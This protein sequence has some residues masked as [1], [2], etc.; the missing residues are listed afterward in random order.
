MTQ[1]LPPRFEAA[2]TVADVF[3]IG[4]GPAG[5]TAATLLA[6]HG[7]SVVL[8]DKDQHP[9]FHIGES[10]LPASMRL[11]QRLGVAERLAEIGV[12]KYAAEFVS[13]YHG[14]TET[15]ALARALDPS[16]P[17]SY[18]VPRAEFDHL[19]LSNASAAA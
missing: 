15:F 5:A 17:Y 9:R 6:Q 14:R 10:L 4:G 19:L 16:Q 13:Q 8:A 1:I 7:R 3:I 11:F 2:S 18:Q 12:A